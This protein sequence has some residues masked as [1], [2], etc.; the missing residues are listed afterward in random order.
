MKFVTGVTG[1]FEFF[2]NILKW[3]RDIQK[4][5]DPCYKGYF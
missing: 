5:A 2:L 3:Q 4:V 1:V